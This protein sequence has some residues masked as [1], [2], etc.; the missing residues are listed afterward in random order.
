MAVVQ[1]GVYFLL[2]CKNA[3]CSVHSHY[4]HISA[5]LNVIFATFLYLYANAGFTIFY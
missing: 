1:N 2:F 4:F 3:K 5:A